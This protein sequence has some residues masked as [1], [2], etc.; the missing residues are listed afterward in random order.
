MFYD[1]D[2]EIMQ[3]MNKPLN[4]I[5]KHVRFFLPLGCTL[6]LILLGVFSIW[7]STTA[8]VISSGLSGSYLSAGNA[9]IGLGIVSAIIMYPLIGISYI[10]DKMD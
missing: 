9:S 1:R 8:F 2:D 7:V 4:F 5:F 3:I 10:I 6:A